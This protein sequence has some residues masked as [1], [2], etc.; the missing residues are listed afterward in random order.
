MIKLQVFDNKKT[1]DRYTV[2]IDDSW[3][4]MSVNA[5]SPQGFN[6]YGGESKDLCMEKAIIGKEIENLDILPIEVK[7][8]ITNRIFDIVF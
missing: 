7:K 1:W 8:A 5:T 6:Q 3:F 4:G 2:V